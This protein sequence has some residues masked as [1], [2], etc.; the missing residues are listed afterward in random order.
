MRITSC[1]LMYQARSSLPDSVVKKSS[2]DS[3]QLLIVRGDLRNQHTM[4][5][6]ISR[7]FGGHG[8][9]AHRQRT[10]QEP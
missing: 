9:Q 5:A 4:V 7:Q 10:T 8:L 1:Q 3:R 6:S 2:A